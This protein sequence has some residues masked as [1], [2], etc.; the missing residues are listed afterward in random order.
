MCLCTCSCDCVSEEVH[1]HIC[2]GAWEDKTLP[3][4]LKE[5][6]LHAAGVSE[7]LDLGLGFKLY[8][9]WNEQ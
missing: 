2:A 7:T 6:D 1:A 9:F 5:L 3:S 4:D 8:S